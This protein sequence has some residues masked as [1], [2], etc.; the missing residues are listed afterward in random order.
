MTIAV[1]Q[2]LAS[3]III[4]ISGFH[5]TPVRHS[6]KHMPAHGPDHAA[7][8]TQFAIAPNY[9]FSRKISRGVLENYLERPVAVL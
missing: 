5:T 7:L 2:L 9:K 3:T 1:R 8:T 4:S 6:N